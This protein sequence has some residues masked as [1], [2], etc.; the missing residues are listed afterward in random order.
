VVWWADA[1]EDVVRIVVGDGDW[2]W[3]VV[4]E[5]GDWVCREVGEEG[6]KYTRRSGRRGAGSNGTQC[7]GRGSVAWGWN[8]T[9][10]WWWRSHQAVGRL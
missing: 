8:C 10:Q 9:I 2:V 7:M 5:E 6:V 3:V 1:A 4:G